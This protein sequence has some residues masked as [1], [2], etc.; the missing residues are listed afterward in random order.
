MN[1]GQGFTLTDLLA[2][3]AILAVLASLLLPAVGAGARAPLPWDRAREEERRIR[4]RRNLNM[5]ARGMATYLNELGDNRFYPCPLGRGL[6]RY[7]YNGAEWLASLYWAK[8]MPDPGIFL[9]PSTRDTNHKGRDLGTH[10]APGR[11]FGSDTVSY[12]AMHYYSMTSR[13]GR[14]IPEAIRD[15]F[16]PNEPMAS[17]DTEGTVNHGTG[18][19]GGMSILFFDSHVEFHTGTRIDPAAAVGKR[20]G[21]LW[22][23]R[24]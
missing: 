10:R 2:S 24:N 16:S 17:D 12:A 13:G 6:R 15:D 1:R 22:R 11:R 19:G 4:C 3:V 18:A 20:P 23:L 8:V 9:C 14:A 7:D 5:F 21:R